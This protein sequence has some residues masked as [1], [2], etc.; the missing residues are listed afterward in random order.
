M[1][2]RVILSVT[3]HAVGQYLRTA[4]HCF[5]LL[6]LINNSLTL[7]K[8][9]HNHDSVWVFDLKNIIIDFC[10]RHFLTTLSNTLKFLKNTP[11]QS[12]IFISLLCVGKYGQSRSFMFDKLHEIVN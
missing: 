11:L 2:I 3:V 5:P 8:G 6:K 7:N 1:L 12:R 9:N 10:S 4:P